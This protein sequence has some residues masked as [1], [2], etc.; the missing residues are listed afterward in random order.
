[1]EQLLDKAEQAAGDPKDAFFN[2]RLAELRG[3]VEFSKK[4]HWTFSWLVIIGVLVMVGYLWYSVSDAEKEMINAKKDV[5]LVKNWAEQDT[6]INISDIKPVSY[7]QQFSSAN[8]YKAYELNSLNSN[9]ETSTKYADKYTA[10]ADTAKTDERKA[11]YK[12]YAEN[13]RK[14]ADQY[15]TEYKEINEMKF[16]QIKEKHW[17]K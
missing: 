3:I 6:V 9:Y 15:L 13:S 10:M 7:T 16:E 11:E 12:K 8:L 17:K 1:M 2:E 14:D 5:E 4:R